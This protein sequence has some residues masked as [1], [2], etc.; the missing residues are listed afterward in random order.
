[1]KKIVAD[2]LAKK[3]VFL[4]FLCGAHTVLASMHRG[5][6]NDRKRLIGAAPHLSQRE[7]RKIVLEE[8]AELLKQT[9]REVRLSQQAL[10]AENAESALSAVCLRGQGLEESGLRGVLKGHHRYVS[11]DEKPSDEKP[12]E[13][14]TQ[15]VFIQGCPPG[16][17]NLY[18]ETISYQLGLEFTR[19][20]MQSQRNLESPLSSFKA[21]KK[22][23]QLFKS[24]EDTVREDA[25]RA[26]VSFIALCLERDLKR[27]LA[28]LEWNREE[29][30][31]FR[32]LSSEKALPIVQERK[33][34]K[35]QFKQS[36]KQEQ[37]RL[38]QQPRLTFQKNK[39]LPKSQQQVK[40]IAHRKRW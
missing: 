34:Q 6:S 22:L 21:Q 23:E 2:I 28:V 29:R 17:H 7:P 33:Q 15:I 39:K 24:C 1:M 18:L 26:E 14:K 3:F 25:K 32:A 4:M 31:D 11:S 10:V 27:D 37:K 35:E 5:L 12:C 36:Y 20:A 19:C 30:R 9:L 13:T 38:K 16:L 40:Q 8:G